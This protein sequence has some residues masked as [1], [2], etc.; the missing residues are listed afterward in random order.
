MSRRKLEKVKKESLPESSW[1]H[2]Q[3]VEVLKADFRQIQGTQRVTW[4]KCRRYL[5]HGL[6]NPQIRFSP[7]DIALVK[8]T[9]CFDLRDPENGTE[10][11]IFL[12]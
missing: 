11:N 2:R 4:F 5:H 10:T 8:L 1:F 7:Y 6:F 9:Q 12:S 3:S